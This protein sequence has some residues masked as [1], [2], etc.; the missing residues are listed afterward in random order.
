MKSYKIRTT[1][2]IYNAVTIDN[3]DD[4]LKDFEAWLR[5]VV[6]VKEAIPAYGMKMADVGFTWN[7]DKE[8]GV[9][10]GVNIEIVEEKADNVK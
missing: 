1:N 2:D 10:K 8:A 7:D 4:F 9:I 3:V 6:S 5:S